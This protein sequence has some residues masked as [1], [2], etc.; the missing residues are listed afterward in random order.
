MTRVGRARER[1]ETQGFMQVLVDDETQ[2]ILGPALLGIEADEAVHAIL[3]V[4]YANAPYTVIQR[5]MSIYPAASE[6]IASLLGDSK[7]LPVCGFGVLNR[8][9]LVRSRLETCQNIL[10]ECTR[11]LLFK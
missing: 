1:G 6:L 5:S 8:P 4:M 3:N 11:M 2:K 9:C 7:P 10:P